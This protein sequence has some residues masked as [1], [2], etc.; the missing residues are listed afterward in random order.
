[1]LL[2]E[3]L[4]NRHGGRDILVPEVPCGKAQRRNR[5]FRAVRIIIQNLLVVDIRAG[6]AW[7]FKQGEKFLQREVPVMDAVFAQPAE[8][9]RRGGRLRVDLILK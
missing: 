5:R 7:S 9:C 4:R 3:I 6:G 8:G 2:E 1:M